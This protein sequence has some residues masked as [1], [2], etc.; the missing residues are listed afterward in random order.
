MFNCKYVAGTNEYMP[1]INRKENNK[2]IL[3]S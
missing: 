1:I 2:D 3:G